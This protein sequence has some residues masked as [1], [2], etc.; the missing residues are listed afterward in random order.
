MQHSFGQ[1]VKVSKLPEV[2]L[3][4]KYGSKRVQ[5][6]GSG[7][8]K[9]YPHQRQAHIFIALGRTIHHSR[10]SCTGAYMLAEVDGGKHP[11]TWNIDQLRKYYA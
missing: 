2:M 7:P 8:E 9:G 4:Q 10:H 5:H 3:Q 6:R 11:N 1:C